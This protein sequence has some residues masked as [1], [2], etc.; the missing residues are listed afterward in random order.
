[1]CGH[2]EGKFRVQHL[3]GTAFLSDA[4]IRSTTLIMGG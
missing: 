3:E 2:D 4:K 1:M